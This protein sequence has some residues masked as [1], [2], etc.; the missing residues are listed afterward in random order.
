MV[1]RLG[2]PLQG[3][4]G[5]TA[6]IVERNRPGVSTGKEE[7]KF[8][9]RLSNTCDVIFEDVRVPAGNRLG[10]EGE[11]FKIAM[12]TLDLSRPFIG[13]IAVVSPSARWTR[14]WP[15]PRPG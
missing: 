13:A 6:F 8:G 1:L 4:K 2:G 3:L 9:I 10:E 5:L 15:T 7:D 11:G 14:L 12:R